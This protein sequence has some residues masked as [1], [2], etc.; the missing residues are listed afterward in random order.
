MSG[1]VDS[2]LA[3][4][5]AYV[6]EQDARSDELLAAQQPEVP[7]VLV[8]GR[9]GTGVVAE[10]HGMRYYLTDCCGASAKGSGDGIVCRGC[11]EYIDPWLGGLPDEPL[12][13][14]YGDG[15]GWDE[16]RALTA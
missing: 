2:Y 9:D 6:A 15:I 1:Y 4:C 10:S 8:L 11:Y 7:E 3:S 14:V 13:E 12:S 16:W 5:D